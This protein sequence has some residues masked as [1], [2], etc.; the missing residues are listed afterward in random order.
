LDQ[1]KESSGGWLVATALNNRRI[2]SFL[3]PKR[4]RG[5][6]PPTRVEG[7]GGKPCSAIFQNLWINQVSSWTFCE[8]NA[9][10]RIL[11]N[12]SESDLEC[13]LRDLL[14][15][16]NVAMVL[17][18]ICRLAYDLLVRFPLQQFLIP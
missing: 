4:G 11:Q 10:T 18:D 16:R 14:H 5:H 17:M 6:P 13:L 8:T 9:Q 1:A 3:D 2:E 15:V 7:E 12:N